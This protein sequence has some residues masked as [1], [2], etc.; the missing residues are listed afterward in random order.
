[1]SATRKIDLEVKLTPD[2]QAEFEA[3]ETKI[4]EELKTNYAGMGIEVR[5]QK[6]PHPKIMQALEREFTQAG[7]DI[8]YLGPDYEREGQHSLIL[9]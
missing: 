8:Q 4:N 2:Q 3:L 1:M 9:R 5:L 6:R 7:W